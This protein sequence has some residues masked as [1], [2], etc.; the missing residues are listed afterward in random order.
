MNWIA[1][2]HFIRPEWLLALIPAIMIAVLLF[3][4]YERSSAWA[5]TI[6]HELMPFLLVQPPKKPSVNPLPILLLAWVLSIL[7]AAGPTTEK[8][9]QPSLEREDALVIVLDLTWSMYASDV[10]PSRLINAK[11][12]ITDLLMA[13]KEGTTG[14]I[15]FAGDAHAVSPLTDDNKTILALLSTL[16]PEMMPAPGSA[17]APALTLA[18]SL[19]VSAGAATG[20][21]LVITDEV[22]DPQ[23]ALRA[24]SALSNQYP[25][26]LMIVG[27]QSGAPIRLPQSMGDKFLKDTQ[28]SLVIPAVNF[29]DINRFANASGAALTELNLLND[30]LSVWLEPPNR[31][32]DS[33]RVVER[34]FDLWEELGPYLILILIPLAILGFRRGWLWGL[35]FI[36]LMPADQAVAAGFWTDL[37]KT[38]DQQG[39]SALELDA[40]ETAATLFE[41][42]AWRA[43]AHYR[44]QDF[45][46]AAKDFATSTGVEN[47]YNRGNALAR[48][49]D[50][51]GALA[52]FDQVL[53]SDPEHEDAAFNKALIEQLL[54]QQAQEQDASDQSEGGEQNPQD[55]SQGEENQASGEQDPSQDA[56]SQEDSDSADDSEASAEEREQ[57]AAEQ[58][59]EDQAQEGAETLQ[60]TD[61]AL[62]PEEAQALE[63]WLKRVPDDPGGLLRRKFEQQFEE[64]VRQGEITRQD[65]ERNW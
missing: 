52:T 10:T 4:R 44:N 7:A 60:E 42:P 28:G 35:A 56:Q 55:G 5:D 12:K 34:D 24:A 37:W 9:P 65:F 11:R 63:Q 59:K 33:F 30:D 46:A 62:D 1:N 3:R 15:V 49:G 17:L 47:D 22:R 20:R 31:L 38:R 26:S 19:F 39:A 51:E 18:R 14:L 36:I 57:T 58:A 45:K 32:D 27:T 25:L 64:R 23:A 16:G 54:E 13:R 2:F 41:D 8:I 50:L 43:T 48:S 40:P 29:D 21:V 61:E 6:D 53:A